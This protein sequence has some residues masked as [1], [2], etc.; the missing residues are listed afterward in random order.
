MSTRQKSKRPLPKAPDN[1]LEAD[2]LIGRVEVCDARL[3]LSATDL[4]VQLELPGDVTEE[5]E[6]ATG[7]SGT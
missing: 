7:S 3:S 2:S 1:L 4:H 6:G 5:N